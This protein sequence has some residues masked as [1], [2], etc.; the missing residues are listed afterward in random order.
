MVA[1]GRLE[2]RKSVTVAMGGVWWGWVGGAQGASSRH[3]QLEQT[4]GRETDSAVSNGREARCALDVSL[5]LSFSKCCF[6]CS[7]LNKAAVSPNENALYLPL[8]IITSHSRLGLFATL[9]NVV[10]L[11]TNEGQAMLLPQN[12]S[13]IAAGPEIAIGR[14]FNYCVWE[15]AAVRAL[16]K[17]QL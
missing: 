12:P 15:D 2:E 5:H 10:D 7:P 17:L 3:S 9:T 1:G 11:C 14:P 13:G 4:S 16:F 6:V 8:Y